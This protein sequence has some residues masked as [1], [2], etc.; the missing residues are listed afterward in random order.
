[1]NFVNGVIPSS[2]PLGDATLTVTYNGR[3]SA[4]VPITITAVSVGLRALGGNGYG[5]AKAWNVPADAPL[6]LDESLI[7][8]PNALELTAKPGQRMVIQGTG[9]GA[10]SV[11]ETAADFV[12]PVDVPVNVVVGNKPATVLGMVRTSWATDYI[13]LQLADDVPTGCLVPVAVQAGGVTSNVVSVSISTDGGPCSDVT[14]FSASDIALAQKNGGLTVGAIEVVHLELGIFGVDTEADGRFGRYAYGALSDAFAPISPQT[15]IRGSFAVPP[16][17]S[18]TVTPGAP[19]TKLLDIPGDNTPFQHMNVGQN[20]NLTGPKGTVQLAS[21]DYQFGTD[22]D[23]FGPGDYTV[24]NGTGT[25]PF[26][27][28]KGAITLPD[29]VK[30]T[31]PDVLG[32][33]VDRSQD[34]T[35]TWSGGAADKEFAMIAGLSQNQT[36]TAAFL[37]TAKVA[38]GTFTIPAWVLSSLPASADFTSDGQTITSGFIGLATAPLTSAARFSGMGLDFGIFTYEQG[39][40]TLV[41]LR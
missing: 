8:I 12:Q 36:A 20:L 21:P 17:G 10:V 7:Q 34:L 13:V 39:Q 24:D 33:S 4:P 14:G 5:P 38:D 30:V 23:I 1:V 11:D 31:N 22:D 15:G 35:L 28:F 37:C 6:V 3:T 29:R 18:C 2:T 16:L 41:P 19:F 40:L 32:S 27:P 9:L 25:A 26:G